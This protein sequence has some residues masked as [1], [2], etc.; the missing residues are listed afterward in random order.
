[1]TGNITPLSQTDLNQRRQRLRRQRRIR[2][3]QS[4]WRVGA[5]AGLAGGL[6]WVSTLPI[7]LIRDSK[8]VKVEGNRLLPTQTI[9]KVLPIAYPQSLLWIRPQAIAQELKAKTPISE[10]FV[11]R[12][13]FPP[14]L[15]VRVKERYP[16]AITLLTSADAA[17]LNQKPSQDKSAPD[18]IGLLDEQGIKIPF[19]SYALLGN[20]VK[21]PPLKVIGNQDYYQP[22]WQTLYRETSRS[23]VKISEIDSQNPA[24]LILKT[25]LG[26]IHL[27]PYDG[28]QFTAQLKTLDRMRKLTNQMPANQISYIDLRNPESPVVQMVGSKAPPKVDAP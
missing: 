13:L 9:Q 16:V 12:Q 19:A 20:A 21:L 8:Q 15:T 23:P 27:G 5:V 4:I 11:S 7:W 26:I 10:A 3:L 2:F 24:N 17:L 1:M 22:Y 25:E 18:R 6:V 28:K 14:G